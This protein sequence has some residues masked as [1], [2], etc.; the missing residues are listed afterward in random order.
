[1][2][3]PERLEV[4]LLGRPAVEVDGEWFEPPPG[5]GTAILFYLAFHGGWVG[6]DDL[7][8]LFW[9]DTPESQARGNL[10]PL[11]WRLS[12]EPYASGLERD[13]SRVRCE[14]GVEPDAATAAVIEAIR[15]AE[16]SLASPPAAVDDGGDAGRDAMPIQPTPFLGRAAEIASISGLLGGGACRIVS[17]VGPGGVGKT[18]LAVEVASC[19]A[20]S[21][22]NGARYVDLASASTPE[23]VASAVA[24]AVGAAEGVPPALED[25]GRHLRGLE[26]LLVLD[27]VE[28]LVGRARHLFTELEARASELSILATL[29]G[30]Q[31]PAGALA[32]VVAA[33][34]LAARGDHAA[35]QRVEAF[36]RSHAATPFGALHALGYRASADAHERPLG[37]ASAAR[38]PAADMAA[39][40]TDLLHGM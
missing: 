13:R 3:A 34:A 4:R 14:V 24:L 33:R 37:N 20:S 28:H 19:R 29:H 18:R 15:A 12:R 10:R 27:N 9:P 35:A 5:K 26:M 1:M 16:P 32:G 17:I 7:V 6:R 11:L 38:A 30:E 22:R 21:F 25:I 39:F 23:A 8:Y 40:L 31:E 2:A 36:V